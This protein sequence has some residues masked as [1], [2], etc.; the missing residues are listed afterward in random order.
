MLIFLVGL[1]PARVQHLA[2][3]L[4][5]VLAT[6]YPHVNFQTP[7]CPAEWIAPEALFRI[8]LCAGQEDGNTS[9]AWRQRLLALNLPFQVVHADNQGYVSPCLMALLPPES[10]KG[11][12]RQAAPLRWQGVC[13]T[14]SDPDCELRLFSGLLQR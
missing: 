7:A 3:A 13:E 11:L 1:P 2:T 4:H 10:V 6:I 14:C 5:Q 9:A 12:S 8:V